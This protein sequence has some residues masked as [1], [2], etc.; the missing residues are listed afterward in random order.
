MD[1]KKTILGLCFL[2]ATAVSLLL[3][4]KS[5]A[6][7]STRGIMQIIGRRNT[8]ECLQS[9]CIQLRSKIE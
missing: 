9:R 4:R 8:D 2:C 3:V 5:D 7:R 6:G 1:H